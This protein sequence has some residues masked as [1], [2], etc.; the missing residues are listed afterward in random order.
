M[1]KVREC[2]SCAAAR[3]EQARSM[4]ASGGGGEVLLQSTLATGVW[5]REERNR[6]EE[7]HDEV[8]RCTSRGLRG[9]E[10]GRR[11]AR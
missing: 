4:G 10:E 3:L 2:R 11:K 6:M 1:M 8:G 7:V 5:L 9:E